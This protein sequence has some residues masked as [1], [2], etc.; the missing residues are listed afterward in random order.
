MKRWEYF[1]Y[2]K[3]IQ[4]AILFN[5]SFICVTVAPFWRI[6]AERKQR[7]SAATHGYVFYVLHALI[8]TKSAYPCGAADTEQHTLLDYFNNAFHTFLDLDSVIYLVVN[9]TVTS[10]P[11][12]IQ[13]ILNCLP[14][15]NKA[16]TGLEPGGKWLMRKSLFWGAVT[17]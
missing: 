9:G 10:L 3:K 2:A 17:L 12:F 6:S 11:V 13:N 8:W 15:T 14:K 16:F 5:N 7:I 1:L 4:I